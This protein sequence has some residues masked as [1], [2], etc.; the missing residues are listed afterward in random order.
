MLGVKILY[1]VN[2]YY[3]LLRRYD[4]PCGVEATE[5]HP[6]ALRHLVAPSSLPQI[7]HL[8]GH[9]VLEDRLQHERPEGVLRLRV[10]GARGVSAGKLSC[11][12]HLGASSWRSCRVES[13]SELRP[14]R[15]PSEV[16]MAIMSG[17]RSLS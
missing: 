17:M 8:R 6:S 9:L 13:H 11:M 4:W 14:S 2:V 3:I 7:R 12:L 16:R 10:L 5:P 1:D 15:L